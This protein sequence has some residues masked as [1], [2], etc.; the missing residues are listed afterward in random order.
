MLFGPSSQK[1]EED[2][3]EEIVE[4]EKKE[5]ESEGD[6]EMEDDKADEVPESNTELK[7]IDRLQIVH[8]PCLKW[9]LQASNILLVLIAKQMTKGGLIGT[10]HLSAECL[11]KLLRLTKKQDESQKVILDG[12]LQ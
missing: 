5:L 4:E 10:E 8:A 7:A 11:E 12:L 1:K 9:S 6:K 3:K 2:K